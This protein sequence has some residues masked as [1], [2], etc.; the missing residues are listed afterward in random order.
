MAINISRDS[1]TKIRSNFYYHSHHLIPTT[2]HDV[3]I[4]VALHPNKI[5]LPVCFLLTIL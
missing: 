2:K 5:H 3:L 1:P 4:Q